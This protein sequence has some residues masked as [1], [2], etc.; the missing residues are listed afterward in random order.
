[1]FSLGLLFIF[2]SNFFNIYWIQYLG[3]TVDVIKE[4]LNNKDISNEALLKVLLLN[5]GIIIGS[6]IVAGIFRFMMRQTIIVASRK[7]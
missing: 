5:A 6:S 2:L 1:M 3:Q 7:I 4:V